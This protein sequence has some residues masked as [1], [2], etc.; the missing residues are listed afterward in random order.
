MDSGSAGIVLSGCRLELVAPVD[1]PH[2]LVACVTKRRVPVDKLALLIS[3]NVACVAGCCSHP[4]HPQ[5]ARLRKALEDSEKER[6][7]F[8]GRV[9]AADAVLS[10]PELVADVLSFYK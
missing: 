8:E 3:W 4:H 5:A 7:K 2:L 10:D 9:M 1:L 6:D